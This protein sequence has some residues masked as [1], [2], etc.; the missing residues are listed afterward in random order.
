MSGRYSSLVI[1][2]AF[3]LWSAPCRGDKDWSLG[4]LNPFNKQP[5]AGERVRA[6][7][8]D[9]ASAESHAA[10]RG[11]RTTSHRQTPS[12]LAKVNQGTKALFS[13]TWDKT[14]ETLGQTQKVLGKTKKVLTPWEW[15]KPATN[16]SS[17]ARDDNGYSLFPSWRPGEKKE[18]RPNSVKEFLALPRPGY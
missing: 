4:S 18:T 8:S 10:S 2:L 16:H 3:A 5:R 15:K 14:K 13:M 17:R 1:F 12:M 6:S 7:L 9:E 11:P